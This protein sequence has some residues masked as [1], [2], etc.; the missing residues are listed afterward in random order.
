MS[1]SSK[2]LWYQL[3]YALETARQR[4]HVPRKVSAEADDGH[5]P[6]AT[7]VRSRLLAGGGAAVAHR[8]VSGLADSRPGTL[9]TARAA[10]AGAGAAFL[11][12]LLKADPDPSSVQRKGTA[13]G[14]DPVSELLK[15]AGRGICYGS[16]LELRLP[17]PPVLRGAAY[18]VIEYVSVPLGGLDGILGAASPQHITSLLALLSATEEVPPGSLAEHAVFGAA[19]GLLYGEGGERRGRRAVV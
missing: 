18:G 11:L 17:G 1:E 7:P 4:A 6:S 15:G 12:S 3:G 14:P 8:L 2:N 19:F 10:L 5:A 9:R 16:L 13:P